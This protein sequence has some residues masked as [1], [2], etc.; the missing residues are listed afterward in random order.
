MKGHLFL[1][2][3][4]LPLLLAGCQG[5]G[6]P[7]VPEGCQANVPMPKAGDH[8]AYSARGAPW[9]MELNLLPIVDWS[10]GSG[11]QPGGGTMVLP[12]DSTVTIQVTS[13]EDRLTR[14]G[15]LEGAYGLHYEAQRPSDTAALPFADAWLAE[16]DGSTVQAALRSIFTSASGQPYHDIRF[17]HEQKPAGLGSQLF[18]GTELGPASHGSL[19]MAS[20]QPTSLWTTGVDH[21]DWR[22]ES[23]EVVGGDCQA[24]VRLSY[25]AAAVDAA[26][27]D[28]TATA[29]YENGTP[30]PIEYEATPSTLREPVFQARLRSFTGGA[31]PELPA[32]MPTVRPPGI[33]LGEPDTGM[34]AQTSGVFAT[35][36]TSVVEES[37]S[38]VASQRWFAD[39]PNAVPAYTAHILGET[40]SEFVDAWRTHWTDGTAGNI[41]IVEHRKAMLVFGERL[42]VVSTPESA[43]KVPPPAQQR[44]S[45][46]HIAGM[47]ALA[48]GETAEVLNCNLELDYCGIGTHQGTAYPRYNGTWPSSS[49]HIGLLIDSTDGSVLTD[50]SASETML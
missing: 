12:A 35:P 23:T 29:T 27:P 5:N 48:S 22:V 8:A 31:G 42:S 24:T 13:S 6:V 39:H 33:P 38:N 28:W 25:S 40:G 17:T 14:S 26:L 32:W 9:S 30:F 34:L 10:I 11:G 2:L 47:F 46:S 18:W 45:L 37:R 21:L 19:G 1:F 3:F 4:L 49:P 7:P 44:A 36:W 43:L 50:Q 15:R 20:D 41:I 16:T